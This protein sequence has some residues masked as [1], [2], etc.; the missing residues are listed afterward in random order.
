LVVGLTGVLQTSYSY[1]ATAV[2]TGL[3]FMISALAAAFLGS[4]FSR[5]G[6]L[7][8]V[9][10]TIAAMFITSL[11]NGLILNGV[12]NLALPAI[13]GG[14]LVVSVLL[15]VIQKRDIGQINIF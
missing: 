2:P 10:T 5:T 13:Q 14:I 7:D 4:T 1:G 8:V 15:S 12:S 9:G 6:E 11:S 3:D